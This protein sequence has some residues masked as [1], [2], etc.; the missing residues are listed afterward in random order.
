MYFV[1]KKVKLKRLHLFCAR[2]TRLLERLYRI[3]TKVLRD[4][5]YG[6]NMK[7][8]KWSIVSLI[9][10][11]QMV[12]GGG[13]SST[14]HLESIDSVAIEEGQITF[15]GDAMVSLRM[16]TTKEY[17]TA[18]RTVYG[19]PV[20]LAQ[21]LS[22]KG[23][24]SVVPYFSENLNGVPTGGHSR[25]DLK[26]MSL[27]QW[28]QLLIAVKKIKTGDAVTITY[29]AQEVTLSDLFVTKMIGWGGVRVDPEDQ[30]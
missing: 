4:V 6:E 18:E 19:Q 17:Q 26:K 23:S 30:K 2:M 3:F 27:E 24:F 20:Q 29:Q 8:L 25:E 21:V 16:R 14:V 28:T 7:L 22:E 9:A 12:L 5:C 15:T 1:S 11:F 13:S 10:C